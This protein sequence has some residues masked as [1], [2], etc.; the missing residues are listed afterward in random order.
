MNNEIVL[1]NHELKE[2]HPIIEFIFAI[3]NKN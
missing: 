3:I 2:D 1:N